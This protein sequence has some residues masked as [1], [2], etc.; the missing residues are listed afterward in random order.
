MVELNSNQN[1]FYHQD[2]GMGVEP[3]EYFNSTI[4]YLHFC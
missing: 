3:K 1:L 4:G 2:M